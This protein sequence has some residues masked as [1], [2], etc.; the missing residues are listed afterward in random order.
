MYPVSEKADLVWS[1]QVLSVTKA[2]V[3]GLVP[4]IPT[5]SIGRS[6]ERPIVRP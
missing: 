2:L 5:T 4:E 1:A 6:P 3:F